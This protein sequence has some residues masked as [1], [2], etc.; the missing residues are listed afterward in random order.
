[1]SKTIYQCTSCG[2]QSSSWYGKC[3]E[4]GTWESLEKIEDTVRSS[5]TSVK[6]S[7]IQLSSIIT[8]NKNR[9][10]TGFYEV[11]RVLGGGFMPGEVILLS[12]EPGV[13][14]STLLL[15]GLQKLSVF[16]ISGEESAEQIKHRSER[17][18]IDP[19]RFYFSATTDVDSILKTLFSEKLPIDVIVIDS[20]QM[21]Y[22]RDVPGVPGGATQIKEVT[23]R[24]AEFAKKSKIPIL[25]I[26]HITKEGN[27]AGP[28][29]LEHLVDCVL[30]LEGERF[31]PYRILR[32]SKNRFGGIDEIG[33]FE[34][35][36]DGLVEVDDP[37]KYIKDTNQTNTI[38]K[39]IV[40]VTEGSR[41]L[42]L[43]IESLVVP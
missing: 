4:C 13:G 8:T 3:P 23:L 9:K 34:M 7:V 19:K 14:K 38:G 39:A 40:G 32:A 43:E 31:S 2:Y 27:I 5:N 37:T 24:I 12:G 41:S 26:G 6:A 36:E 42:F 30:Y 11:D 20:I 10:E 29:T 33:M 28:K 25:L 1:M 16:Y 35:G 22:T 17:L 21:M 15:S 18:H